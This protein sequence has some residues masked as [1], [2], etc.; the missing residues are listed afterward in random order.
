M[1]REGVMAFPQFLVPRNRII[2]KRGSDSG[3]LS[4]FHLVRTPDAGGGG[5]GGS[6]PMQYGVLLGSETNGTL[7][8]FQTLAANGVDRVTISPI[9][10]FLQASSGASVTAAAEW[11]N[12]KAR[13]QN[14]ATAGLMVD[15][16][17]CYQ[18]PPSWVVTTIPKLRNQSSEDYSGVHSSG[19]EIRDYIWT[20]AGRNAVN[21]FQTKVLVAIRDDATLGFSKLSSVRGIGPGQFLEVGYPRFDKGTPAVSYWGFSAAAQAGTGIASDLTATT[22]P[23]YVPFAGGG[24]FGQ[25]DARDLTWIAWY[26]NALS[27]FITW[28]IGVIRATGWTGD[29]YVL[30]PSFGVRSDWEA[31]SPIANAP[32]SYRQEMA[33]GADPKRAINA[34]KALSKVWPYATWMEDTDRGALTVDSNKASWRKIL[35]EAVAAGIGAQVWGENALTSVTNTGMNTIFSTGAIAAGVHG[36]NWL[37]RDSLVSGTGPATLANYATNIA[38]H[39]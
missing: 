15:L 26:L 31:T 7:A 1:F 19:D 3:R 23:G 5:G 13:I 12:V 6:V 39:P 17:I 30:H 20:Q 33:S 2:T 34:Y 11:A 32:T 9:W 21:D 29:L 28:D 4:E 35:D 16:A 24:G 25:S 14:A 18:Y 27:T 8:N 10:E 36:V 38:A 22:L 37:H